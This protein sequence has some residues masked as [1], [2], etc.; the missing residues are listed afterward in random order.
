MANYLGGVQNLLD[1]GQ[2]KILASFL[3]EIF[4]LLLHQDLDIA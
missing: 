1:L 3:G 4:G 2:C